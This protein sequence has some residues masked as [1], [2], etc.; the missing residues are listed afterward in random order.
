MTP[1]ELTGETTSCVRRAIRWSSISA[2]SRVLPRTVR[3]R[4][5]TDKGRTTWQPDVHDP[6][7][8]LSG[9]LGSG[10]GPPRGPFQLG[11]EFGEQDWGDEPA[12][13]EVPDAPT[14]SAPEG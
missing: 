5:H 14:A 10:R 12:A 2:P 11:V 3:S 6:A 1:D 4:E 8:Q 7:K 13:D 9:G